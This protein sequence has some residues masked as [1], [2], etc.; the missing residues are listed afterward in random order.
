MD[1]K[2]L[3]FNG[4]RREHAYNIS[5]TRLIYIND[6]KLCMFDFSKENSIAGK[7]TRLSI[8]RSWIN[9]AIAWR[10]RNGKAGKA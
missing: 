7:S 2:R 9:R 10:K 3:V 4:L 1:Y 5:S 6:G 8:A